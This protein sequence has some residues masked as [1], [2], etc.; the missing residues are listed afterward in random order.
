MLTPASQAWKGGPGL[1]CRLLRSVLV[2]FKY[3]F[4]VFQIMIVAQTRAFM[5]MRAKIVAR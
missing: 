1:C 5:I 4:G 2:Q 3:A